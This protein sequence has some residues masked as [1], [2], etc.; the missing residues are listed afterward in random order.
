MYYRSD[1]I[2]DSCMTDLYKYIMY[3][4]VVVVNS[5]VCFTF[6]SH[7]WLLF[8]CYA[9]SNKVADSDDYDR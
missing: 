6:L 5:T 3:I 1:S 9:D 7:P 8:T 4:H 2:I